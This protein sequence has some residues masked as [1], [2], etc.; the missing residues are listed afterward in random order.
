MYAGGVTDDI[1][2]MKQQRFHLV[3][4]Q[5]RWTDHEYKGINSQWRDDESGQTFEMQYH[6]TSSFVAKQLTHGA[7]ECLRSGQIAPEDA[8][9]L[10]T[11]QHEVSA[12]IPV[13]RGAGEISNYP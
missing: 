13:P 4:M 7:Y 5:N 8:R 10:H 2:R 12:R 1:A 9:D 3:K 11:F 6:T